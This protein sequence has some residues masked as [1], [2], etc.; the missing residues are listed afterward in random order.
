MTPT[1]MLGGL[2]VLLAILGSSLFLLRSEEPH[3]AKDDSTH[4]ERE[5]RETSSDP[6]FVAAPAGSI[7]RRTTDPDAPVESRDAATSSFH[8]TALC[9]DVSGNTV[10]GVSFHL[11]RV[12]LDPAKGHRVALDPTPFLS[13]AAGRATLTVPLGDEARDVIQLDDERFPM[14]SFRI[15]APK[16]DATIDLGTVVLEMAAR[17]RGRLLDFRGRP[18][19]RAW[20][21][22]ASPMD[23]QSSP[24]RPQGTSLAVSKNAPTERFAFERLAP[25][26]WRF[27]AEYPHFEIATADIEL[28]PGEAREITLRQVEERDPHTELMLMVWVRTGEAFVAS[29]FVRLIAPGGEEIAPMATPDEFPRREFV[30]RHLGPGPYIARIL[31]PRFEPWE[32]RD[33]HPGPERLVARLRGRSSI[34]LTVLDAEETPIERYGLFLRDYDTGGI[35]VQAGPETIE[36]QDHPNGVTRL[37]GLV[38]GTYGYQLGLPD[39]STHDITIEKLGIGEARNVVFR[40]RPTVTVSGHVTWEHDGTSVSLAYVSLLEPAPENDSPTCDILVTELISP[41]QTSMRQEVFRTRTDERGAFRF[42]SV[43]SGTWIVAASHGPARLERPRP[44]TSGFLRVMSTPLLLT[45][46]VEGIDLV[47][48]AA[49]R[50]HVTVAWPEAFAYTASLALERREDSPHTRSMRC[51]WT[52]DPGA[53]SLD[54]GPLQ[55]GT[56]DV[57]TLLRGGKGARDVAQHTLEGLV[58]VAGRTTEAQIDLV[59]FQPGR[60]EVRVTSQGEPLPNT[61]VQ[62]Q[63]PGSRNGYPAASTNGEGLA[64]FEIVPPG[65]HDAVLLGTNGPWSQ[66]LPPVTIR[67]GETQTVTFDVPLFQRRIVFRDRDTHALLDVRSLYLWPEIDPRHIMSRDLKTKTDGSIDLVLPAG[68]YIIRSRERYAG[69]TAPDPTTFTW[70][71]PEGSELLIHVD[72]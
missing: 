9:V 63:I 14:R 61:R 10:P 47:L 72:Q 66:T 52:I 58:V 5:H 15:L 46:S 43:P 60:L 71:L 54:L 57:Q 37:A 3:V 56:Y 50:L 68:S 28:A 32:Q 6:A 39:G 42:E 31:D 26:R 4:L 1:R 18:I 12:A 38:P 34:H 40:V 24:S 59:A 25:G 20:N 35:S 55:P 49:G 65:T 30:F 19:T 22:T 62:L 48:P 67:P 33:V 29:E 51:T 70:P 21:I 8:I 7:E 64:V 2:I 16:P 44:M 23:A 11:Q 13:D 27:K 53:P 17:V 45:S 41:G 36:L 69:E